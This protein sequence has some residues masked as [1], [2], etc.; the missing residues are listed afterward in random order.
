METCVKQ[1]YKCIDFITAEKMHQIISGLRLGPSKLSEK[2]NVLATGN[3]MSNSGT[4]YI[5]IY[6]DN[7][8][9][10]IATISNDAS[11]SL[12]LIG[13][14]KTQEIITNIIDVLTKLNILPVA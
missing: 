13:N 3:L 7:D 11:H 6:S 4:I 1:M 2:Y 9:T 14:C 10:P 12:R 8:P 5:S